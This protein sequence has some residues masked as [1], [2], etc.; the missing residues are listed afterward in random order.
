MTKAELSSDRSFSEWQALGFEAVMNPK[1]EKEYQVTVGEGLC[2][3]HVM[4]SE[5]VPTDLL[6]SVLE[7]H[8]VARDV[9]GQLLNTWNGMVELMPDGAEQLKESSLRMLSTQLSMTGRNVYDEVKQSLILT[10]AVALFTARGLEQ[11]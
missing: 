7:T 10:G 5:K 6:Q 1:I 8:P 2:A 3:M 4:A 9:L 11:A